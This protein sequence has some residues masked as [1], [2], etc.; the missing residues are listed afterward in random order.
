MRYT[1]NKLEGNTQPTIEK[2]KLRTK[3]AYGPGKLY[4]TAGGRGMEMIA[5]TAT[6]SDSTS[7]ARGMESA[8]IAPAAAA[9]LGDQSPPDS[10]S[11][12]SIIGKE[13]AV[14]KSGKEDSTSTNR[15][16]AETA[17]R[18]DESSASRAQDREP[19]AQDDELS[20]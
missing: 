6:A 10:Q 3:A 1:S 18:V 2:G 7:V 15:Q 19:P 4:P 16:S 5:T 13:V 14:D 17:P 9:P 20:G 8:G 12:D 11:E